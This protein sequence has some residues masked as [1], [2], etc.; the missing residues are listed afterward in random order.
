MSETDFDIIVVGS[1]CAGAVAAYTAATAGKS[2]LVVERGNF[3]GAKNMTGGRIYSHSLKKVFPDFERDAPLERKI[4]HERISMLDVRSNMTIDFTSDE[5]AEEG[6]DSYTVLRAPFDQWL[7]SK[8]EDAGAEYICGIAVE[9][10]I[11][12]GAG[13]VVGVRAGED[14]ITAQVVILAEGVNTLLA[15]KCLGNPRP[16]ASQMAVGIKQ[17]FELPAE[18]IEDRFLCPEGEGSAMLFV[19]DCT[20]GNVGGGFLYTNKNSISLGLVATISTAADAPNPYPVYQ[21]LEDFKQ[22]PAVAPI[23]R[24]AKLVEHSG[25][26]VP[27]GGYDMVPKYVFDG[28]LVAGETAGLCMNMGYQVRGMDFAVASGR[29]AAEA[30]VVAI[31]KGDVSEGGLVSYKTKM[32]DSFV[33]QD[34]KTFSKWPRVMEHWDSMFNDYPVMVK[35]I[36]N[37]MFSVDGRPQRPLMKRM[38][39]IVKKRGLL[40]LAGEVRKAV[41]S[42]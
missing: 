38:M 13:R 33:I 28:C 19:G 8:A 35:E 30:A 31:D 21:M 24:G 32:E 15:E 1:G 20:H 27:E 18:R 12:D 23:I 9:E 29:M 6:K 34:L 11:K 25:H 39:P 5:L 22:H 41:K 16:K 4:T 14:E 2:V 17:V 42:L 37:A 10:L 40:K 7:A 36:F 26:M 3:A